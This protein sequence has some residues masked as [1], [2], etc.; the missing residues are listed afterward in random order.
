[1]GAPSEELG[2]LRLWVP[3]PPKQSQRKQRSPTRTSGLFREGTL[4]PT[5]LARNL[6]F[7]EH[8]AC[9]AVYH[10]NSFSATCGHGLGRG[11]RVSCFM[12]SAI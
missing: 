10:A 5:H 9:L 2:Y 12:G 8:E 3:S 6:V 4:A 1:M 11:P 7:M